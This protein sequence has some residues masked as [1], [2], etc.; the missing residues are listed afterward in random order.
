MIGTCLHF[1]PELRATKNRVNLYIQ[2]HWQGFTSKITLAQRKVP[3]RLNLVYHM[4]VWTSTDRSIFCDGSRALHQTPRRFSRLMD[5]SSKCLQSEECQWIMNSTHRIQL[6]VIYPHLV[7]VHIKCIG[8]YTIH[9]SYG[10]RD[11]AHLKL[12]PRSACC[13]SLCFLYTFRTLC[14]M[15]SQYWHLLRLLA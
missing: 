9:G 6:W 8:K 3:H 1:F 10:Q 15:L 11:V 5:P 2:T 12:Q 13:F 7:D 14:M 4:I